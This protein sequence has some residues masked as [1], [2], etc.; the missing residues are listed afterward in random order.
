MNE[1]DEKPGEFCE[2]K[3]LEILL[4]FKY[5][6]YAM[7]FVLVIQGFDILSL[8]SQSSEPRVI[9][10]KGVRGALLDSL[11]RDG[12][13]VFKVGE[14]G[15]AY[16][17]VNPPKLVLAKLD[18]KNKEVEGGKAPGDYWL[19]P[20]ATVSASL[21]DHITPSI[22]VDTAGVL[23]VGAVNDTSFNGYGSF[24]LFY[25]TDDG[26]TWNYLTSIIVTLSSGDT[27]PIMICAL[28]IDL[29]RNYL[30]TTISYVAYY[31]AYS[32]HTDTCGN[33]Y[34]IY[35]LYSDRETMG[36]AWSIS[37]SSGA[38]TGITQVGGDDIEA[39]FDGI[40]HWTDYYETDIWGI[41]CDSTIVYDTTRYADS[42]WPDVSVEHGY[43]SPYAYT[44]YHYQKEYIWHYYKWDW[45]G[46]PNDSAIGWVTEGFGVKVARS[47][48][49]GVNWETWDAFGDEHALLLYAS[50]RFAGVATVRAGDGI[51]PTVVGFRENTATDD[52][53]TCRRAWLYATTNR[54]ASWTGSSWYS[55]G[56]YVDQVFGAGAFGS[57]YVYW[58]IMV[59]GTSLDSVYMRVSTDGGSTWSYNYWVEASGSATYGWPVLTS[60]IEEDLSSTAQHLYLLVH[61]GDSLLFKATYPSLLATSA[62]GWGVWPDLVDTLPIASIYVGSTGPWGFIRQTDMTSFYYLGGFGPGLVWIHEY[63]ADDHDIYFTRPIIPLYWSVDEEKGR[64][65]SLRLLNTLV[66]NYLL[67]DV[68]PALE[69]QPLWVYRIDGSLVLRTALAPRVRVELPPGVYVWR[70]GGK[71][72]KF[73]VAP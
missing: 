16:E 28:D 50:G 8:G 47:F 19:T 6:T 13:T 14:D 30:V 1:L 23:W 43:T 60:E 61:K 67:F 18:M 7:L 37:Y 49:G 73:T 17:V 39:Y 55:S 35:I 33:H 40:A 38:P 66:R 21:Y 34:E 65:P 4:D 22:A 56:G 24:D 5:I 11:V 48:D 29:S 58:A 27:L 53:F 54:G 63:A 69:G 46:G 36:S 2:A 32:N 45:T 41:T 57:S 59:D 62:S 72:G 70:A 71:R 42:F 12:Y 52:P 25:S 26:A 44:A 64:R 3:A 10:V 15:K 9:A 31:A 51:A 68:P 20:P